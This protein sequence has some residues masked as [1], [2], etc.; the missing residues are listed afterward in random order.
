MTKFCF[1]CE[2]RDK[3]ILRENNAWIIDK[4]GEK[5]MD[6]AFNKVDECINM[7]PDYND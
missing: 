2:S 1:I 6:T 5:I 7:K 4:K 3:F